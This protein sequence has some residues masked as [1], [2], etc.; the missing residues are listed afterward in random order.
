MEGISVILLYQNMIPSKKRRFSLKIT[1][2]DQI[3][4]T[5]YEKML[6]KMT[7]STKE[8][9]KLIHIESLFLKE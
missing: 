8:L 4:E 6:I 7:D 9:N 2:I 1:V 3:S 5:E